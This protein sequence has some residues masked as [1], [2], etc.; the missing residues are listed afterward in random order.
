MI[1][2]DVMEAKAITIIQLGR[3]YPAYTMSLT[4]HMPYVLK[5]KTKKMFIY[6]NTSFLIS[7]LS[8]KYHE[9]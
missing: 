3:F 4:E 6:W 2:M 5:L 8:F 7:I 1:V 9:I